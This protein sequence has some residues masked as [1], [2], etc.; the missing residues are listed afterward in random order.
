MKK[1]IVIALISVAVV[2]GLAACG[3][4]DKPDTPLKE[5]SMAEEPSAQPDEVGKDSQPSEGD[6]S[7][8]DN[9]SAGADNT[10]A[11]SRN[12]EDGIIEEADDSEQDSEEE[13]TLDISDI[14]VNNAD[15]AVKLL[16][17]IFG[18]E[19]AETGYA[20]SFGYI[21]NFTIDGTEYYG[22]QWSW[23]V[24]GDHLSRLTDIF[25]QTD[26]SAVYQG[27]YDGGSWEINSGNML[28]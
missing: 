4:V 3:S 5:E 20:Y 11:D 9:L 12:T 19:D 24:D 16:E 7:P 8:E 28:E 1:K 13:K 17:A 2:F 10:P 26:G 14:K 22:F 18:T 21:D 27:N 6:A 23:L 15:D 25:V